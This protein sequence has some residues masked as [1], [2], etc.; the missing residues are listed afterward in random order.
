[1][2]LVVAEAETAALRAELPHWSSHVTSALALVEVGR[3][4]RA[5]GAPQRQVDAVL[6]RCSVLPIDE[7][8]LQLA[9]EVAPASVRS[10]DAIH[11]ASALSLGDALDVLVT[12]DRRMAD[13]ARGCGLVV[14][15]PS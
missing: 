11:I 12:Y 1:M 9:V 14:A 2:K 3:A 6:A 15:S 10:L 5:A 8:R 7:P 13:A 4:A